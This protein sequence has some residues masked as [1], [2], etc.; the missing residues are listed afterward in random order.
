MRHCVAMPDHW[1]R[2]LGADWFAAFGGTVPFAQ[3][4]R[5]CKPLIALYP[6]S[7]VQIHLRHYLAAH[8]NGRA[9]YASPAKFAQTFLEWG[10]T[11]SAIPKPYRTPDECDRAAGIAIKEGPA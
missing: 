4:G 9:V 10:T 5:H 7:Q 2:E 3:L 1:V 6:F 11:L 8:H